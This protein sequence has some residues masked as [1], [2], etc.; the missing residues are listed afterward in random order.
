[1]NRGVGELKVIVVP[2]SGTGDL[3]GLSGSFSIKIEGGKHF[4]DFEYSI[5]E[6]ASTKTN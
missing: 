2:D 5:T 6:Q 1:M 3:T 4:Y